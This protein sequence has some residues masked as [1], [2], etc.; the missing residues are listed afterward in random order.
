MPRAEI[1]LSCKSKRLPAFIKRQANPGNRSSQLDPPRPV[2]RLHLRHCTLSFSTHCVSVSAGSLRA[3]IH[4]PRQTITRPEPGQSQTLACV[5]NSPCI[6]SQKVVN[7]FSSLPSLFASALFRPVYTA[8]NEI[9]EHTRGDRKGVVEN[10]RLIC[11]PATKSRFSLFPT[12]SVYFYSGRWSVKEIASRCSLV[13]EFELT[14][15]L[16]ETDFVNLAVTINGNDWKLIVT[17]SRNRD[18]CGIRVEIDDTEVNLFESVRCR[19]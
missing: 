16:G 5:L 18:A 13:H 19:V 11:A 6:R 7:H 1:K 3:P 15:K 2:H 12:S 17:V 9:T 4:A 10:N 14:G 8:D